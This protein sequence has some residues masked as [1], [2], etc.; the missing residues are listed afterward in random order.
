[1]LA[2]ARCNSI[3]IHAGLR[4]DVQ[5][6]RIVGHFGWLRR[7]VGLRCRSRRVFRIE[8]STGWM[9]LVDF[10][11]L[12]L[13]GTV[14]QGLVRQVLGLFQPLFFQRALTR[15]FGG[16]FS[17]LFLFGRVLLVPPIN[18]LL[19]AL[20]G[21]SGRIVGQLQNGRLTAERDRAAL[22]LC[23]AIRL[24]RRCADPRR[25]QTTAQFRSC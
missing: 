4:N 20:Y 25:W 18:E 7:S 13:F 1:M 5:V 9:G 14:D 10:G 17:G 6:A 24:G 2:R 15:F 19:A 12:A 8:R 11:V 21:Y 23:L 22:C 16:G 3:D